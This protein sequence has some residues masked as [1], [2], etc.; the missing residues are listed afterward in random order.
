MDDHVSSQGGLREEMRVN[1]RRM[2][3]GEKGEGSIDS[4]TVQVIRLWFE[5]TSHS[6]P[7]LSASTTRKSWERGLFLFFFFFWK[8]HRPF[9]AS[10]WTTSLTHPTPATVRPGCDDLI[11]HFELD[12]LI[13]NLFYHSDSLFKWWCCWG[14]MGEFSLRDPN[15]V[16]ERV[17]SRWS[18]DTYLMTR[19]ERETKSI[20]ITIDEIEIWVTDSRG[21][22]LDQHFGG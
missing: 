20:E 10:C 4:M 13:P 22:V 3:G 9:R 5:S 16:L 17:W 7:K 11:T 12:D 8:T 19:Y 15:L 6:T 14:S 1:L 18:L 2:I 21:R